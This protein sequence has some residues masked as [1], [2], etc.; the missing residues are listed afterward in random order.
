[1]K[2]A[3]LKGMWNLISVLCSNSKIVDVEANPSAVILPKYHTSENNFFP[4]AGWLALNIQ[5]ILAL[6]VFVLMITTIITT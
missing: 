5:Y 1:M 6:V 4:L 2:Q 3:G